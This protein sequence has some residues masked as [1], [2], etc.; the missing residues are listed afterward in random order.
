MGL[1]EFSGRVFF[2]A[3]VGQPGTT[4]R[5]TGY[6]GT[7]FAQN[8]PQIAHNLGIPQNFS[9]NFLVKATWLASL[10]GSKEKDSKRY[11]VDDDWKFE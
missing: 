11:A 2:L 4:S 6:S 1:A 9:Q 7:N 5:T 8:L 10:R 3:K